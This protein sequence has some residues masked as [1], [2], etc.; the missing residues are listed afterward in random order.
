MKATVVFER[1][2]NAIHALDENGNRKY[3]YIRNI[4]SSRSSKTFSLI[5]CFDLYARSQRNKRLTVW[6]DTKT[7][8]KKT[9]LN[10]VLRHLKSTQRYKVGQEF[11]KTESIFTYHTDSTFEIHGTDDEL[12]VHGLTQS[13]A[14]FNE[15]YK[16]S[17]ETFDQIDQRTSD[18]IVLDLNPKMGHWSDDIA[19]DPRCIT[20][21]STFADN[22]FCPEESKMK[23]LSYQPVKCCRIV[24]EK[25]L[26][27]TEARQYDLVNNPLN[28]TKGRLNELRRCLENEFKNSANEF[29]WSVYGLGLKAERPNRIFHWSEIPD[30]DYHQLQ[31]PKYTG[32]DWGVVHP[33]GV[34]EVKYFDGGLYLHELNYASENELRSKMTTTEFAQINSNDEGI[35]SWLFGKIGVSKNEDIICDPNRKLKILALREAGWEY[36]VAAN[37]YAGSVIDGIAQLNNMK[38][39]YT[40]SSTNLK[41]EQ[42]NYSRKI[43]NHGIILEEPEDADNHLMDAVRYVV[44]YLCDIGVITK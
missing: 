4:G 30:S 22:P 20:I 3:R 36:S 7:D 40:K 6:R 17:K 32:N 10:D 11:N 31:V 29:N 9:V 12:A 21:H 39:F 13:A 18:F 28:F 26:T 5:D 1:N 35:V 38:V 42:E 16:I 27:E 43:D 44:L 24:E 8:C 41:Y 15:P 34:V 33:W 2:W 23:I 19:K 37:K 25:I 14:W